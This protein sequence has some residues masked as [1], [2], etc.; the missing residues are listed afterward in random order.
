MPDR[1][2]GVPASGFALWIVLESILTADD[3][4]GVVETLAA[5]VGR[6]LGIRT[7]I[8]SAGAPRA[9]SISMILVWAVRNCAG[10]SSKVI[11]QFFEEVLPRTRGF[12]GL[13]VGANRC[14]I[15]S[16]AHARVHRKKRRCISREP[17]FFRARAGSPRTTSIRKPKGTVLPRTRGFTGREAER[18]DEARGSSAHARVHRTLDHA[19]GHLGFFRARAGSPSCSSIAR[20]R[21]SVL[22]RT[23]RVH[24]GTSSP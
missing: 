8:Y 24:R 20:I 5:S 3:A 14:S 11:N 7:G 6:Q 21:V 16:S 1:A 15:G 23:A 18:G 17:R 13:R 22:P 10:H 19:G 9:S 12:T 4:V 2:S